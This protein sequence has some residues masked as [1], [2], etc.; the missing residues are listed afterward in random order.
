METPARS[1]TLSKCQ[2]QTSA[3]LFSRLGFLYAALIIAGLIFQGQTVRA[4]KVPLTLLVYNYTE[5]SAGTLLSAEREATRILESAKA[6]VVWVNCWDKSQLSNETTELCAKGWTSQTPALRLISGTNKFL[7]KEFG[8]ASI[9][10]YITIYYEK[11]ARRAHDDNSISELPVLLGCAIAHELGH[12]LMGDRGH[13][14]A[15]IMQP[16][17]G[18]AQIRQALTGRL[19]FTK[20]QT[21]VIQAHVLMGED[22]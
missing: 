17:W 5:A 8:E 6:T 10:V 13:S 20:E 21:K 18:A 15:G 1:Q 7:Y 14:A 9:P 12:L 19:L 11:I 16:Q 22:H 4:E 2:T 3:R